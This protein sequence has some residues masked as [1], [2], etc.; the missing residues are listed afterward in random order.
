MSL[1]VIA[2]A[3]AALVSALDGA[4]EFLPVSSD[5][6]LAIAGAFLGLTGVRLAAVHAA[7][8]PA[9]ALGAVTAPLQRGRG[10]A[11]ERRA[12]TTVVRRSP[13]SFSYY[14]L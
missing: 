4:T 8:E 6:H 7:I 11:F 14:C 1:D 13:A 2:L 10:R 9:L 12:R 5:G 3:T